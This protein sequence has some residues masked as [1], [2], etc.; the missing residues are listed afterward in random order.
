[1]IIRLVIENVFSFGKR[2]EFNTLPNTRLKTLDDHKYVHGDFSVLKISSLYGANGAGKSNLVKVLDYFQELVLSEQVPY[3]LKDSTFKFGA[4]SKE[5]PQ[6]FAVEFIQD[7]IPFYYGVELKNSQVVTE[8]LYRSGLG[9]KNDELIFERTTIEEG[10][11]NL[12]FME[13]FEADERGQ[14]LKSIL[15]EEFVKPGQSIFRLLSNRDNKFL[16][17]IKTAF[18]WFENT[19]QI[20]TPDATPASLA[21]QID[22]DPEFKDYAEEIMRSFNL[23]ITSLMSEKKEISEFFGEDNPEASLIMKKRVD[24]SPG[25]MIGIR[26]NGVVYTILKEGEKYWV[27]S[28]KIEHHGE[29]DKLV[30]FD[31][32]EESDGTLRLLDFVPAFKNLISQ[33]KVYV[34]DEIERSIHPLLIKELIRKFSNDP[35]T[36]GQL[37]FTTHE[38]NLLDQN[39]FRQDEIWFAEKD[40]SGST[41]LYSLSDFKEHKTIDI[42]KGYLN[43][44]YGSIPFLGNLHDLNWH[45]YVSNEPTF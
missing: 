32:D 31:L 4:D 42:R 38:S 26:L 35:N 43:G 23:G 24:E 16:Q 22:T 40:K 12:K 45:Q 30:F 33:E 2:K 39:L 29:N 5:S 14:L 27:K 8:E 19:L 13:A 37:V 6:V 15:L 21:H 7:G 3:E 44:R 1:M 25:S 11:S 10:K 41:D 34:V 20:I 17:D 18:R 36:K 28:L 9:K